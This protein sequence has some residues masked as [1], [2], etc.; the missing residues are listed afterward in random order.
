MQSEDR[1][2]LIVDAILGS[3]AGNVDS[4]KEVTAPTMVFANTAASA[5]WLAN[6]MKLRG[7]DC[8]EFHSLLN[9]EE[10]DDSLQIF[11]KKECNLLICTDSASRGFDI[12]HV[13]HVIQAEFA[14]NVVHH[15]HRIGRASRAGKAG[16]ATMFYDKRSQDLVKSIMNSRDTDCTVEESF[17]RRRGFRKKI[18]KNYSN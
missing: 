15:L 18:K 17:S 4:N 2:D 13:E 16:K 7:I 11:K 6:S 1:L 10:K 9:N 8:V 12:P 3:T 14:G 5:R